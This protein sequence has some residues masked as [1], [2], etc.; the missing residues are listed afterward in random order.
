MGHV[1]RAPKKA[2][3]NRLDSHYLLPAQITFLALM[4]RTVQSD[5]ITEK[6]SLA[7]LFKSQYEG[8][9]KVMVSL[10]HY[11][12]MPAS[13][14]SQSTNVSFLLFSALMLNNISKSRLEFYK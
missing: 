12:E 9:P 2:S 7:L 6:V 8:S 4:T 14:V 13:E 11:L 10:N 1:G 5:I 3:Q